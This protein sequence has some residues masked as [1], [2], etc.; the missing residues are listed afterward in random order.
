MT[1]RYYLILRILELLKY[2]AEKILRKVMMEKTM[3]QIR[4]DKPCNSSI[5]IASVLDKIKS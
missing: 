4:Q 2:D 3:V 1:K 5:L